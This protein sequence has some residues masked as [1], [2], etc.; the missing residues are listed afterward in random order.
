MNRTFILG[1]LLLGLL[2]AGAGSCSKPPG[3]GEYDRALYE[4]KRN[5][6]VR[7]KALLEKSISRRPGAEENALAYNYL[8]VAAGKLGQF[9][10]AQ[11]A[12][13]DSRRLG[14]KLLEPVL[15]LAQL[16]AS[17]GDQLRALKLLEEAARMDERD[18]R[19]LE[20]MAV[21]YGQRQQWPEAQ[22]M[23]H[24]ALD[25][26]PATP[27]IHTAIANVQ[28]QTQ[29][30]TVALETLLRAL[31]HN[32]RYAPALFNLALIYDTRLQDAPHARSY[33]RRF[34]GVSGSGPH[35]DFARRALQRIESSGSAPARAAASD[36]LAPVTPEPPA[37]ADEIPPVTP[38]PEPVVVKSEPTPAPTPP[39]SAED[40]V[41]TVVRRAARLAEQGDSPAAL[42]L[43][44]ESAEIARR[45]GR[46][47]EQTKYIQDAAR[48]CFDEP[49]AHFELGRLL[50]SQNN[51]EAALK[52]FK[53]ATT[54]DRNYAAAHLALARAAL[55]TGE[56]DAALVGF[57]SAAKADPRDANA[58]WELARLL[59]DKMK[60]TERALDTYRDFERMFP[61]DPRVL[62]AVERARVLAAERP[63]TPPTV[64]PPRTS[65]AAPVLE[66]PVSVAPPVNVNTTRATLITFPSRNEAAAPAARQVKY[67]APV[68][69]NPRA[70][71]LAFNQGAEY[72]QQG[73][74]D[75]AI[76]YY[77]RSLENDDRLGTTFYNLGSA[78]AGRGD[79]ELAKDAYLRALQLQPDLVSARYNLALLYFQAGDASSAEKMLT[80]VVRQKPDYA[81]AHYTLGMIY[82]K[83]PGT[84]NQARQA[85]ERYVKLAP[86]EPAAA[87][88]RQWLST[89]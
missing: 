11:E 27:R 30:P 3:Q 74:W 16:A 62:Q 50:I 32:T 70:A 19:A 80:E 7:A 66:R 45:K 23:L 43:L 53:Q 71:L 64:A 65:A 2:V 88:V 1:L 28:A 8:G 13:E 6:A 46:T 86:N 55:Q 77:L 73:N 10:A 48:L 42:N 89:H 87:V 17:S 40:A 51:P 54:L 72:Q 52:S 36:T 60:N 26:A 57:Q 63:A 84:L 59:D 67:R 68:T 18:T 69:P 12:F 38:V 24:A 37:R 41:Q 75:S 47:E 20:L 5:N 31:E 83:S 21:L 56:Y 49:R 9:Q 76:Y 29:G 33:Y 34:L 82:A 39:P 25:R 85:Y 35:A 22:R 58:A 81:A 14:P 79:A 4:L 44:L 15:N 61:G 78:Y